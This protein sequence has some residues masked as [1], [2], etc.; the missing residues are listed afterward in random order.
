[1]ASFG[2]V[3]TNGTKVVEGYLLYNRDKWHWNYLRFLLAVELAL[4]ATLRGLNE[5]RGWDAG[6][7][8]QLTVGARVAGRVFGGD[9]RTML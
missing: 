2:R 5:D 9:I 3:R 6:V 1:M 7:R 8:K 4:F